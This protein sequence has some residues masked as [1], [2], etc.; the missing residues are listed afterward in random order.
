M[1]LECNGPKRGESLKR[2]A[3]L[4]HRAHVNMIVNSHVYTAIGGL[5][6]SYMLLRARLVPRGMSVLGLIRYAALLVASVLAMLGFIDLVAGPG[7]HFNVRC[8]NS[9]CRSGSSINV[10]ASDRMRVAR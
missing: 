7:L 1:N 2:S 4:L 10:T 8:S 3:L 6:L 9:S 5:M